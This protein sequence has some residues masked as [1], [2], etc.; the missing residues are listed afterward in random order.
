MLHIFRVN[1]YTTYVV[2]KLVIHRMGLDDSQYKFITARN[3]QTL[4][5][6]ITRTIK[7]PFN[8]DPDP[9]PAPIKFWKG[10]QNLKN[11]DIFIDGI[12]EN[13]VF[14]FYATNYSRKINQ[15]IASH[16]LCRE[17]N[18]LEEGTACYY[19]RSYLET[20]Y[21]PESNWKN[22]LV[23]RCNFGYRIKSWG[24]A[25]VVDNYYTLTDY[26]LPGFDATNVYSSEAI[27][28][29]FSWQKQS[30]VDRE[31]QLVI[32][33]DS[34][35]TLGYISRAEHIEAVVKA[36]TVIGKFDRWNFSNVYLKFH[37]VQTIDERKDFKARLR[38]ENIDI[39]YL[40]DDFILESLV[41]NQ[42]SCIFIGNCSSIL[43]YA[44][45]F[46]KVA[47]SFHSLLPNSTVPNLPVV[48]WKF[49]KRL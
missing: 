33:L 3:L 46:G 11:L 25:P 23:R 36:V 40:P 15:F 28:K 12:V 42:C 32:V 26:A 17:V 41:F 7:S 38:E 35:S 48:Y 21:A 43:L 6:D 22:W 19:P 20:L 31:N 14:S 8:Y 29:S 39:A 24:F 27:I 30:I 5:E 45:M 2:A 9:F 37:P 13:S 16:K 4:P 44:S 47:M 49:V 10:R 1:N 34:L 18:F